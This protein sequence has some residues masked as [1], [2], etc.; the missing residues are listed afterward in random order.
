MK[1]VLF[2][3]LVFVFI[4]CTESTSPPAPPDKKK[5]VEPYNGYFAISAEIDS[6]D[7][8]SQPNLMEVPQHVTI[9]INGDSITIDDGGGKPAKGSWDAS[10]RHAIAATEETCVP[11]TTKCSGCFAGHFDITFSD[12]TSF[13]GT[14]WIVFRYVGD[15]SDADCTDYFSITGTRQ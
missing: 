5:P 13:T 15:C 11:V 3:F 2:L 6:F 10:G 4:S 12:S 7:C 8:S 14:Y 9:T 1:R